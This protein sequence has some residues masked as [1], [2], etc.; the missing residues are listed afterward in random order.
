[1]MKKKF[2]KQG[3][4]LI[5]LI[6]TLSVLVILAAIAIPSFIGLKDKA[7]QSVCEE[8]RSTLMREY[9]VLA[10]KDETL[11]LEKHLQQTKTENFCPAG[12]SYS[13]KDEKITCS[14]HNTD[15]P[16]DPAKE[17]PVKENIRLEN[18]SLFQKYK[19][20]KI[21]DIVQGSDG[22]LYECISESYSSSSDPTET[23]GFW[24]WKVISAVNGEAVVMDS[25]LP[26]IYRPG[27]TVTY[28]G[29]YYIYSPQ[30]AGDET[31]HAFNQITADWIEITDKNEASIIKPNAD[32]VIFNNNHDYKAGQ[33]VWQNNCL[34]KAKV[35]IQSGDGMPSGNTSNWEKL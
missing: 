19:G 4:T 17:V 20:Y 18:V 24:A 9:K 8:N 23:Y 25:K 22:V 29:K 5:E 12:G 3:F 13:V 33:V 26:K 34:Y 27:T 2:L 35:D 15:L 11:T 7:K 21:G 28:K 30:N 16:A 32:T 6:V 14:V 1:M 10:A 31:K